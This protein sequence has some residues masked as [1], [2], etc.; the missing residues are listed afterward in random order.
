MAHCVSRS[1]EGHKVQTAKCY[2]VLVGERA[3]NTE[4]KSAIRRIYDSEFFMRVCRV[5]QSNQRKL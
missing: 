3:G 4:K 5:I 2:R 1:E